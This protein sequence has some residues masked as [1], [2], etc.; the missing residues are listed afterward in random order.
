MNWLRD[1]DGKGYRFIALSVAAHNL[2]A[3]DLLKIIAV[4]KIAAGMEA[5]EARK[6]RSGRIA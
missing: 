5:I 6:G 2:V 4:S 1:G 3:S